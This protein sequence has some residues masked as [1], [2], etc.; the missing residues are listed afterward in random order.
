MSDRFIV[1]KTLLGPVRIR[2]ALPAML[3]K[4]FEDDFI[5][6]AVIHVC[7]PGDER[8]DPAILLEACNWALVQIEERWRFSMHVEE[9]SDGTAN[10]L[11]CRKGLLT[12]R[13]TARLYKRWSTVKPEA[14]A[15]QAREPRGSKWRWENY[16]FGMPFRVPEGLT[17]QNA[18]VNFQAWAKTRHLKERLSIK[19]ID[20]VMWATRV[21]RLTPAE[22]HQAWLDG[23]VRHRPNSG[24]ATPIGSSQAGT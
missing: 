17:A 18:I 7:Q 20:G 21:E 14:A 23:T 6:C 11:L 5:K 8:V 10:Y 3:K 9:Q 15:A 16:D 2:K 22:K 24:K 19:T 1:L 4:H 13:E 12:T